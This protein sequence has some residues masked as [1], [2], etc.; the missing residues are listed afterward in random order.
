MNTKIIIDTMGADGG[1]DVILS[2][3]ALALQ[4]HPELTFVLTGD[5]N[6]ISRKCSD[7]D[8]QQQ[9]VEIIN[10]TDEIT[11]YDRPAEALFH[12]TDSSMLMGL[13][14]LSAREDCFG[15]VSC[16]NT[17]VLL[18][19]A[20]KWLLNSDRQRPALAALLPSENGGFT[21]VVDTGAT[22][23]C[24]ASML[25]HFAR[26][27]NDLMRQ[28]YGIEQPRIG[29]LSNGAEP[30]K[31]NC[32]TKEV[33]S[34]LR[35]DEDLRFVGNIEGN[36]ALSGACDVLVCDGFAGNQVLKV[37]EG[38]IRRMIKDMMEY[39]ER[40]DSLEIKRLCRHLVSLYDITSLGGAIVLGTRK[41]I[42]KAHGNANEKTIV[43]VSEMLLNMA[44][45]K[46]AFD[47]YREG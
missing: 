16:G 30:T 20:A 24:T 19:G 21:C 45:H 31:G 25:V 36:N 14:T 23:D 17:G 6:T 15:M 29:L 27:G 26:L 28:M 11:N 5:K 47:G 9:R 7:L 37:T 43:S 35:A 40:T 44:Q 46:T 38:T 12:K 22:V 3:A 41:P 32:L 39:A 34:L 1:V 2:G 4:K 10:A 33:H 18:S 8:I 42:I 13:Q